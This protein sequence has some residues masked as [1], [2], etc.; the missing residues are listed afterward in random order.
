[1]HVNDV[2]MVAE[3]GR[4]PRTASYAVQ[5]RPELRPWALAW[6][7]LLLGGCAVTTPLDTTGDGNTSDAATAPGTHCDGMIVQSPADLVAAHDCREIDGD[8]VFRSRAIEQIGEQDLPYLARIHGSLVV[9]AVTNLEHLDLPVLREVGGR[10]E[11]DL[12][13]IGF[14]ADSLLRIE[15]PELRV[16]HGSLGVLALGALRE[17]DLSTLERVDGALVLSNLPRLEV[18]DLPTSVQVAKRAAFDYLCRLEPHA[19]P[20]LTDRTTESSSALELGC[21]NNDA[22]PCTPHVCQCP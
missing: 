11:Q 13:E 3:S 6:S 10:S 20:A 1:M 19:L 9:A 4:L 18:L 14:E 7:L 12:V 2:L 21:C 17:L 16:V 5:A 8:L 22:A 15:L